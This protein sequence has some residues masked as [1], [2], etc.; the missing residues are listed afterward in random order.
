MYNRNISSDKL[1]IQ[2]I[3]NYDAGKP[4]QH[5]ISFSYQW[6]V[7]CLFVLQMSH[8]LLKTLNYRMDIVFPILCTNNVRKKKTAWS[9]ILILC[10][11]IQIGKTTRTH[12]CNW[13]S[14]IYLFIINFNFITK[15]GCFYEMKIENWLSTQLRVL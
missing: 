6:T 13:Y 12:A 1:E 4:F 15:T 9:S 3:F 5:D 2:C 10:N 11:Q 7:K 14:L 8:I